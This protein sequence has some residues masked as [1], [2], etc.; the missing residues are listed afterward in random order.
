[1]S[2]QGLED[3]AEVAQAIK[4]LAESTGA[5]VR[6]VGRNTTPLIANNGNTFEQ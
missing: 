6:G 4:N 5:G 3:P 2:F 1:M